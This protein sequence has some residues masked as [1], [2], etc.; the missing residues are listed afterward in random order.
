MAGL[1][2]SPRRPTPPPMPPLRPPAL[3]PAPPP[4][5]PPPI[6]KDV[7]S[8]AEAVTLQAR[9]KRGFRATVIT[10]ALEPTAS[11]KKYLLGGR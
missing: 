3:P 2:S 5:P 1:F 7:G 10:G 6:R 4:L 8:A 11:D 9:R